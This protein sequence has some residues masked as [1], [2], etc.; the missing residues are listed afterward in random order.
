MSLYL[1][2]GK[3]EIAVELDGMDLYNAGVSKIFNVCYTGNPFTLEIDL[4]HPVL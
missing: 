4:E 3:K 2:D 1:D